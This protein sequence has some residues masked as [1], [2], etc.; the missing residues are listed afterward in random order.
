[1]LKMLQELSDMLIVVVS[2]LTWL[3]NMDAASWMS[4]LADY[5]FIEKYFWF[6]DES[7]TIIIDEI[8]LNWKHYN[9]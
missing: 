2:R 7:A 6:I 5:A 9:F 4:I 8:Q 3:V 1:M